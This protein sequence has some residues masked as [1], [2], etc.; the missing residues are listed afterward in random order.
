MK[1][2]LE[3]FINCPSSLEVSGPLRTTKYRTNRILP[4]TGIK[5]VTKAKTELIKQKL[6]KRLKER[7]NVARYFHF[8]DTIKHTS[9]TFKP[10]ALTKIIERYGVREGMRPRSLLVRGTMS[11]TPKAARPRL[12]NVVEG[13]IR[14][15]LSQ[16]NFAKSYT[17]RVQ[18]VLRRN[19][20]APVLKSGSLLTQKLR[21]I[22]MLRLSFKDSRLNASESRR[23]VYRAGHDFFES[24]AWGQFSA[25]RMSSKT[26]P[27][28]EEFW[29]LPPIVT[30][31]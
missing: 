30:A 19:E 23:R 31:K 20:N 6:L 28:N 24:I 17:P 3:I 16:R 29:S 5:L 25:D 7:S 22:S 12:R 21:P 14:I 2:R 13:R 26:F 10:N 15:M 27:K 1:K 4:E 9:P 8:P 11:K 18:S